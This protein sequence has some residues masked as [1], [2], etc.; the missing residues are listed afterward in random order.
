MWV[1]G[2]VSVSQS[3]HGDGAEGAWQRE[4]PLPPLTLPLLLLC[5]RM[6]MVG[7]VSSSSDCCSCSF[8]LRRSVALQL[9]LARWR[10]HSWALG[11]RRPHLGPRGALPRSPSPSGAR[12]AGARSST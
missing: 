3:Q 2:G 12:C 8:F 10:K 6:G 1:G 9:L 7:E 4:L 11:P 5:I